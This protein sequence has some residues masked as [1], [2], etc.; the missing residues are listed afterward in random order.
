LAPGLYGR[1]FGVNLLTFGQTKILP[2]LKILVI[3]KSFSL[4]ERMSKFDP[5]YFYGVDLSFCQNLFLLFVEEKKVSI[6]FFN[7]ASSI[8]SELDFHC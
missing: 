2:R 1:T 8:Q 3:Q 6:F 4:Q 5:K 7:Q